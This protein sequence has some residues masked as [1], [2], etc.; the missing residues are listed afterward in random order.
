[1]NMIYTA[2]L[3]AFFFRFGWN[4]YCKSDP[5]ASC[6]ESETREHCDISRRT[7]GWKV[8]S[9]QEAQCKVQGKPPTGV[10]RLVLDFTWDT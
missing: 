10:E 8:H 3:L 2:V 4:H 7:A 9:R 1:M 6:S 5:A